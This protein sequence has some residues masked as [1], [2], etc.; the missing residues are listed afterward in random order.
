[1]TITKEETL[2]LQAF[3]VKRV[4]ILNDIGLKDGYSLEI[5]SYSKHS[6]Y[7]K[8]DIIDNKTANK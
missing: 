1:M 2:S 4:D 8:N 3:L 6:S 7:N 5:V